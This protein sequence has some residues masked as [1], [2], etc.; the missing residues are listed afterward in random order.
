MGRRGYAAALSL[1]HYQDPRRLALC[2]HMDFSPLGHLDGG[3]VLTLALIR[4][5]ENAEGM[6]PR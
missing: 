2:R 3:A 6:H 4:T 5:P 1:P